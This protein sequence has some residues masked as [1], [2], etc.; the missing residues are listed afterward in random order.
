MMLIT[1]GINLLILTVV[2]QSD[3]FRNPYGFYKASLAVADL[4][5]GIVL[6]PV[7]LFSLWQRGNAAIF[8]AQ[9]LIDYR[10]MTDPQIG[11][12]RMSS[13]MENAFGFITTVSLMASIYTLTFSSIDRYLAITRPF[14]YRQG[15][16]NSLLVYY[17]FE[18]YQSRK[19]Q[20]QITRMLS[21]TTCIRAMVFLF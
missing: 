10:N 17:N 21:S 19:F 3:T 11:V 6:S 5:V 8:D 7:L 20:I 16:V 15:W 12:T 14:Q 4:L 1:I 18:L 2:L 13:T 9:L